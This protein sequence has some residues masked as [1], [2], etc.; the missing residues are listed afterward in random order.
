MDYGRHFVGQRDKER[1][2][3]ERTLQSCS[4]ASE[5]E[6][7]CSFKEKKRKKEKEKNLCDRCRNIEEFGEETNEEGED[8]I[9]NEEKE[10]WNL[11]R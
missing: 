2:I 6:V 1:Y 4:N 8:E 10:E 9:R 3:S 7:D 11:Q 5:N